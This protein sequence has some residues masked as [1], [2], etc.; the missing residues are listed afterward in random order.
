MLCDVTFC[1]SSV[2]QLVFS[3]SATVYGWPKEGPCTEESPLS[4]MSPYART[5]VLASFRY[6]SGRFDFCRS[7]LKCLSQCFSS[8]LRTFAVMYNE[9][10]LSGES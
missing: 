10:I 6:T 9:V 3:S 1:D 7:V 5:K 4:G 8:S 2:P